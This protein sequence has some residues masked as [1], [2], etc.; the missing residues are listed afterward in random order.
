[1]PSKKPCCE[2]CAKKKRKGGCGSCTNTAD[3][4]GRE[5]VLI[6]QQNDQY[7]LVDVDDV[8]IFNGRVG[9]DVIVPMVEVLSKSGAKTT[10]L[11][12]M[13]SLIRQLT[14]AGVYSKERQG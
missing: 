6:Y 1:M 5:F 11:L 14:A 4:N 7:A 10:L 13:E 2:E 3:F 9:A 8:S 12:S